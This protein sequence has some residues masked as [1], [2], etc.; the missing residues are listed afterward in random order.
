M[1]DLF[2]KIP[3]YMQNERLINHR[4]LSLYNFYRF[5]ILVIYLYVHKYIK[6]SLEKSPKLLSR[7]TILCILTY[8]K[9][10]V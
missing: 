4:S 7:Y 3:I 8:I 2:G 10:K 9:R 1:I 6:S 5:A